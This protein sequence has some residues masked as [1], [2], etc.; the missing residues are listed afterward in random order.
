MSQKTWGGRFSGGTDDRV[1]AFT[2]SVSIDRRLYRH[3][4]RASQAHARMLAEVGLLTADEAGR[5]VA[6]LDDFAA[7]IDAGKFAFS[8]ALV[9]IHT[10]IHVALSI[11]PTV[12]ISE[13]IGRIKGSAAHEANRQFADS[14]KVLEWQRGYGVVSFGTRQLPWVKEYVE[15]QREHHARGTVQQRLELAA[16]PGEQKETS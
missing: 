8:A 11:P 2:E 9:D 15:N 14:G 7:E 13:L 1:E 16:L 4:V 12:L 6:A 3:D 5:I 10:H